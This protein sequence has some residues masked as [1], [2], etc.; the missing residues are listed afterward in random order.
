M[1]LGGICLLAAVLGSGVASADEVSLRLVGE[2]GPLGPPAYAVTVDGT[3]IGT[4]TLRAPDGAKPRERTD[5]NTIASDRTF[6]IPDELLQAGSV[7]KVYL[8]NDAIDDTGADTT[9][10]ILGV[11]IDGV[12]ADL[13]AATIAA[14]DGE[15]KEIYMTSE[16]ALILAWNA[17]AS[18]TA[19]DGGWL[20]GGATEAAATTQTPTAEVP[21]EQEAPVVD[22]A[23]PAA[24]ATPVEEMVPP[25]EEAAAGDAPPEPT[26]AV[27]A[28]IAL[29]DFANGEANVTETTAQEL[30]GFFKD[31]SVDQCELG[32]AG[33]SSLGGEPA[34]N[35]AV[36][37]ARA[38]AV[39]E[40]IKGRNLHF[41]SEQ[42]VG[43]GETSEFGDGSAN[44]RVVVTVGP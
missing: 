35:L 33:Y 34:T 44:R 30:I 5:L 43:H 41:A 37:Q 31:L 19:P 10:Y 9:L 29:T 7:V 2:D 18:F 39:L 12:A 26:C 32:V 13:A 11:S 38:D 25:V 20:A 36:S 16:G 14:A 42:A 28:T 23:P 15:A 22:E 3:L 8:I 17:A 24:A 6:T 21:A 27:D 1:R 40:F 4:G